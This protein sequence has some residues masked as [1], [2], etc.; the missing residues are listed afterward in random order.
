MSSAESILITAQDGLRLHVRS[1]GARTAPRLPVVCLPGLARTVSDFD[2]LATALADD[3]Q[4]PRWVV[5]LDSRGRGKSDYDTDPSRYTLPVELGD[6]MTVLTA[7]GIGRAVFVGTSRGGIL[8]MLL[9]T[10]RP[11]VIAGC[12][13]NDIGPVIE[14][15]GLARIK[16]YVGRLP[17]PASFHEG[18]DILRRLFGNEF[19]RLGDDDWVAFAHRTFKDA[20][21]RIVADYDVRLARIL[22]EVDLDRPVPTLWKELDALARVPMMVIRGGNSDILSTA[23]VEAM[24][25]RR[26]QLDVLEVP[27]QGHAPI[28]AGGDVLGAIAAFVARCDASSQQH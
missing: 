5:A 16:S 4:T 13:L 8:T 17:Q 12:V 23:T 7:L 6:L 26:E 1:Q 9:A 15:K 20:G 28:L 27:D 19:P 11:T 21:K 14:P 25:A 22:Q 18:A 2:A 3:A 10:Q 24:R